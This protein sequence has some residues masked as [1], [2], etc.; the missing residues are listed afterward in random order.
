MI[1]T[2]N[3]Y[4]NAE[5]HALKHTTHKVGST[6]NARHIFFSFFFLFTNM[7]KETKWNETMH[8]A[9]LCQACFRWTHVLG[10]ASVASD[11]KPKLISQSQ[12]H[13]VMISPKR[14]KNKKRVVR[15]WGDSTNSVRPYKLQKTLFSSLCVHTY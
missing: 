6:A 9:K 8:R 3:T 5:T 11:I 12:Q 7:V 15:E 2:T 10:T 13:A 1:D 14:M 4:L